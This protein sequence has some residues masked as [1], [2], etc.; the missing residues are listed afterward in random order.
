MIDDSMVLPFSSKPEKVEILRGPNIRPLPDTK[1]LGNK[2]TGK[3]LLKVGDDITTDHIMPAGARILPLRSNI[4]AISE[5]VFEVIDA[6]FSRRA[7]KEGGGFI[8]GG[9]N[10]GQGSSREHA[11]LACCY[12]GIKAVI[13]KTFSRIHRANL[14]NSGILPLTFVD[15]D[16]Y[17]QIKPGDCLEI[18]VRELKGELRVKIVERDMEILVFHSLTDREMM[19]LKAGGAL[20]YFKG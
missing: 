2:L 5:Y 4:P 13:A 7:K 18:D 14:I 3:V 11:A 6:E 20:A 19:V 17:N 16:G 15:E 8:V 9:A 12:L 10:Y 1:P